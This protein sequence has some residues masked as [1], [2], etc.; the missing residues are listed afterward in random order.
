MRSLGSR[1]YGMVYL[2]IGLF[3]AIA[4]VTRFALLKQ[5][6]GADM[7]ANDILGSFGLGLVY[8]LVTASYFVLPLIVYLTLLPER[9]LRSRAQRRLF[10]LGLFASLYLLLFVAVAEWIFWEE[11]ESRFN[12]IA[13]D[14]L[15]YTNEVLG[16]IRESYPIPA[17]LTVIGIAALLLLLPLRRLLR[18][19]AAPD[20]RQPRLPQAFALLALPL[21]ATWGLDASQAAFSSNRYA[22]ELAGNGIYSFFAAFRN[23]EIDYP[24]YYAMHDEEAVFQHLRA[25]LAEPDTRFVNEDTHDIARTVTARGAEQRLNVVLITVESLS[26]E[27]LGTFGNTQG[28]TPHL[29]ALARDSLLFTN[30]YATGTRTDRGLEAITLSVPPTAGRSLVKR[31]HNEHLFSLGQVFRDHGYRTAFLYGGYGYFDNMNDF[32]GHNGFDVIDRNAIPPGNIHFAN[33]WGVAD[34]DLYTQTLTEIDATHAAGTPFFGLVMTT[35]N[36][37]PYTYP[38][39]RIDIPSPGGRSGVVKYTD[40]AIHDFLE[41]ARAKPW[42]DDT[43]FVIVADHC[44]KSAGK[45]ALTAAR[46]RIPLLIYSPKHIAAAK[47]DRLTSQIDLAPTLLG[48]LDFDYQT[49]FY[50]R[51]VLAPQQPDNGRALIGTYQKLGYIKDGL[52]TVLSP[53]REV[54]TYRL[55]AD[56]K[57]ELI[58][59]TDPAL[60]DDAIAYYEGAS[61]LF[62]RHQAQAH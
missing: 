60:L 12:F 40:Y 32:F 13:V 61:L 8:D 35:S 50:G 24:R 26:A 18:N 3:L 19:N 9:V 16:N 29:D 57:Q 27:F 46:Y 44:A 33:V 6:N 52:L 59:D 34:E 2:M 1:R 4:T 54:E 51:D 30:V 56:G 48:L 31:P 23:N 58:A 37:R 11:F 49:R 25:L 38:D 15:V 41:R 28:L 14:Y 10:G 20:P 53:R 22:N 55:A 45:E 42:F 62:A 43:V 5:S 36:H 39:G 21:L 7:T 17:L 47:V